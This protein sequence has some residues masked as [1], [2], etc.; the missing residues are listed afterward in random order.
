MEM[1]HVRNATMLLEMA[2]TSV[3]IDPMLGA[4]GSM[5]PF[6][7]VT[8]NQARN[9]LVDLVVP[10]SELLTPDVVVVTHTHADHWDAEA[11]ALLPRE[12]P[13]LVQHRGDADLLAGQG[14]T[15]VRVLDAPT[16]V[17]GVTFTRTGGQHGSDEVLAALPFL[18]QVMGVVLSHPD[19]PVLYLAGDTVW[20]EEVRSALDE[21]RPDV[22]VLNTGE[23]RPTDMGPILMGA[24]DVIDVHRRAP[25]ACVVA[26]HMEALN[27][28]PTTRADVRALAR[29]HELDDLVMV[30]EDGDLLTFGKRSP[31]QV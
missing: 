13:V 9:P 26:V 28:C 12:V 23:A 2:G 22:I 25:G 10:V 20:T 19:E 16:T 14:F 18:G 27:H 1:T 7:S 11:A 17:A 29:A 6:P 30:P 4:K 31:A 8:G 5:D 21:H 3:L 24:Q 15:D